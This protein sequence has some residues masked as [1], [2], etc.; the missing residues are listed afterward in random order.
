MNSF[1]YK[2][3]TCV[4]L[5]QY[6]NPYAFLVKSNKHDLQK[7]YEA[8]TLSERLQLTSDIFTDFVNKVE[9]WS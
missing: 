2:L 1:V 8:E 4:S 6:V 5:P 3:L 7:A 9:L